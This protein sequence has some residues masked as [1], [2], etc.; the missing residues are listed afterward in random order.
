MLGCFF[1]KLT[2]V[3]RENGG[4]S[5]F[6]N[7]KRLTR[8]QALA[9]LLGFPLPLEVWL[10]PS[11]AWADDDD[12]GGDDDGGNDHGGDGG[13]G[14]ND[15]GDNA[16]GGHNDNGDGHEND[17]DDRNDT[18]GGDH[19]YAWRARR[20]GELRSLRGILQRAQRRYG[21]R[22][23]EVKLKQKKGRAWYEIRILDKK[24]RVRKLRVPA[25][26]K[27]QNFNTGRR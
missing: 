6:S 10:R 2:H 1:E 3:C 8:R 14:D 11:L 21:G 23:L 18:A 13:H 15:D 12:D 4:M 22:V 19:D 7:F 25:T 5:A 9:L 24:D 27:R 17:D 16:G 26:R 20:R